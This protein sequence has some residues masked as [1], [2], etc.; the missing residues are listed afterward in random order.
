MTDRP[1]DRAAPR[2]HGDDGSDRI[3]ALR[4][5]FEQWY[6]GASF[7]YTANPIGSQNCDLQWRAWLASR[8]AAAPDGAQAVAWVDPDA[9]ESALRVGQPPT[10]R[11]T[12][13][14]AWNTDFHSERATMPLYRHPPSQ[15]AE[16]AAR[17]HGAMLHEG[18]PRHVADAV[19]RMRAES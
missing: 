9:L 10:H 3:N 12:W 19:I 5:E 4:R 16:D 1:S 17:W 2:F 14:K 13:V 11:M 18:V 15:D 6:V 8:N 7:D